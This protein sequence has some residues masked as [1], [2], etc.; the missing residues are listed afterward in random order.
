[1]YRRPLFMAWNTVDSEMTKPP[2]A[3][4]EPVR[5]NLH[6]REIADPYRWLENAGPE[7]RQRFIEEQNAHT[8]RV[9]EKVPGRE[10][11][12][13]RIEQLLAIGRVASPRIA[14]DKYFYERRDGRQNQPVV[15]VGRHPAQPTNGAGRPTMNRSD[16]TMDGDDQT[17][18]RNAPKMDGGELTIHHDIPKMDGDDQTI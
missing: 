6:G 18:H 11:L 17:I 13:A 4:V 14:G 2:A 7:E 10:R 3:R 15:Y 1:M 16:S 9:L 8:R 12:R 5:E